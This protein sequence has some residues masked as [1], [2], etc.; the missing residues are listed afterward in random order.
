MLHRLAVLS[1]AAR[2]TGSAT[3]RAVIAFRIARWAAAFVCSLLL[4][5]APSP[6]WAAG[7]NVSAKPAAARQAKKAIGKPAALPASDFGPADILDDEGPGLRGQA[8]FYGKAFQGRRTSTGERFDR[9][10]FTAASNR[11]PLGSRVAVRRVDND[12]CAIVKI[13]DRMHARHSKRVID[14][15]HGVA[16]YLGMLRAGVVFVRVAPVRRDGLLPENACRSA[17]EADIPCTD[18]GEPAQRL[19]DFS[20]FSS[21]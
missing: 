4:C 16:E 7:K 5:Q 15:S 17:F 21:H 3:L 1:S 2:L 12:R 19:L 9:R 11:F 20:L 6:V 14:V 13:N 8:S 18:C 10:E